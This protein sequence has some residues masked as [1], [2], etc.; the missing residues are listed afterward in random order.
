M[1]SDVDAT[2]AAVPEATAPEPRKSEPLFV[3]RERE[4]GSVS[5][6]PALS[7]GF[8]SAGKWFLGAVVA[9]IVIAVA[10]TDGKRKDVPIPYNPP[11]APSAAPAPAPPAAT[12]EPL[13]ASVNA[14]LHAAT[15][16]KAAP[17]PKFAS[18]E[19][20]AAWLGAMSRR[21]EARI[22][23]RSARLDFLKTVY[24]EA[25]RAGLD[26]QLVLALVDKVS[27]FR[28]Y[29]VSPGGA[30]GYMQIAPSWVKRIG[31][32]ETNLFHLR[33]N[34][35]YGCT[36]L[37]HYLDIESG[38]LFRALIRYEYD[39]KGNDFA[40][41]APGDAGFPNAVRQLWETKWRWKPS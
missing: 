26:P 34:L 5:S 4:E 10:S 33:T 27:G 1:I 12:V 14:A 41:V 38:D 11:P 15:V 17:D 6:T 7:R 39:M 9:V 22:S 28:K 31:S 35:R 16:D 23:D 29:E 36:I 13:A 24:Y 25:Q 32:E 8:S 3:V 37:R 30:Q 20:K 40:E 18:P 19:E 2:I 21:L